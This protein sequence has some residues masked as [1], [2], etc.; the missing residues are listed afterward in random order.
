MTKDLKKTT[1]FDVKKR[2]N[3]LNFDQKTNYVLLNFTRVR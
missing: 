2:I 3:R 1:T